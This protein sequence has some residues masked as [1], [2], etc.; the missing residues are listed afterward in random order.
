[1]SSSPNEIPGLIEAVRIG[2]VVLANALGSSVM[3]SPAMAA[4][5]PALCRLVLGEELKLPDV[6]TVW[7]G[8]EWGRK[9]ALARLERV[10]VRDA[11]EARPLFSRQSTARVGRELSLG[12][13]R[14]LKERLERR[15]ATIVTQ[16]EV[17]MGVAPVFE[18]GK[19]DSR[20]FSM[21]VFAAWTPHGYVVMPGGLLRLAQHDR[22]KALSIQSGASSKDVW[23]RGEG[24]V[25]SFSLLKPQGT[26]IEI[27]RR[28]ESP[29]SRAMDNLFW[30]GRYAER[31]ESRTRL[32][33]TVVSRLGDETGSLLGISQH[34]L[35]RHGA[36][37]TAA[38]QEAAAGDDAKL[39]GELH[40]LIYDR[41][42]TD[43]L[44]QLLAHVRQTSWSSRDRLSIDTW[45]VVHLLTAA[46]DGLHKRQ[47]RDNAEALSYLDALI[48]RV[49]AFSGLCAEN[50]TRGPNWLFV[51]L[52]RRIER[53][54]Q[55]TALLDQAVGGVADNETLL[56]RAML[57]I[58]DSA[59]TSRS[60]YLNVFDA[61]PLLDLLL[62]DE[63][64]P[65]GVAF[66]LSAIER[67]LQELP[68][69]TTTQRYES[70]LRIA[71]DARLFAKGTNSILLSEIDEDSGKRP[72]LLKFTAR[73][74]NAMEHV[75]DAITDA[76]FQHTQR[77]RT[78][79]APSRDLA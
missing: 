79:A 40:A 60:R 28:G 35:F 13:I 20:P 61:A 21:R 5:L 11:F 63:T 31:A 18:N 17:H 56:I 42:R 38:L 52:G 67:N 7:C 33:R 44:Q 57:E 23:V 15:G 19:F 48:R 76:Y 24:P 12:D 1:M 26:G 74:E 32:L 53:V 72:T 77:R 65:R 58:A 41:A 54:T 27:R 10:I 4:Y 47:T 59:M 37:A 62:L 29:P 50:M 69:V 45:R 36:A 25:D 78:G 34:Y 71:G 49:A 9:E 43:G 64:N 75:N 39:R 73:I 46:P 68:I 16:D 51:D 70:A 8:T 2:N 14:S 30:L 3:E 6:P 66:Q 55:L 22:D